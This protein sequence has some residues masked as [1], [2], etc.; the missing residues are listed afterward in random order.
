MGIENPPSQLP[1][2]I[3]VRFHTAVPDALFRSYLA[4]EYSINSVGDLISATSSIVLTSKGLEDVTGIEYALGITSVF[5]D[6]ND[7]TVAPDFSAMTQLVVLSMPNS[8]VTSIGSLTNLSNIEQLLL[9]GGLFTDIGS[10]E[11]MTDATIVKLQDND[12]TETGD[13]SALVNLTIFWLSGNQ[14]AQTELEAIVDDLHGNR[15]ALGAL[16]CSIILS[17][18]PGSAAT[19]VSRSVEIAELISAGCTVTI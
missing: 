7:I 19:A 18:N 17:G 2:E 15:V 14:I 6:I 3:A 1:G 16:S 13:V 10:L 4:S 12:L 5:F 8:Q 9:S 11:N